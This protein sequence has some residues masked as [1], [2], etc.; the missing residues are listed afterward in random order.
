MSANIGLALNVT[1]AQVLDLRTKGTSTNRPTGTQLAVGLLRYETDTQKWVYF[2]NTNEWIELHI[3]PPQITTDHLP[4]GVKPP[5]LNW[6]HIALKSDLSDLVDNAP[7]ALNTLNELAAALNDDNN[8]FTTLRNLIPAGTMPLNWSNLALGSDLNDLVGSAPDSLNTLGKLATAIN[9]ESTFHATIRGE[10]PAGTMPVNWSHLALDS[11]LTTLVGNPP[12]SLNTLEKLATAINND[13]AFHNYIRGEIPDGTRPLNWSYLALDSDITDLVGTAPE[14]LNTLGKLA[15]AIPTGSTVPA[16]WGHIALA[17]HNHDA[18]YAA[19]NHSHSYAAVNHNHNVD[20]YT[21]IQVDN[22]IP[23]IDLSPYAPLAG[24]TFTGGVEVQGTLTA[25]PATTRCYLG[26]VGTP[27]FCGFQHD[28]L[29]KDGTKYA[30]IQNSAGLT[31]LN[32]SP[33]LMLNVNHVNN[34]YLVANLVVIDVALQANGGIDGYLRTEQND[35][36][37]VLESS[38]ATAIDTSS[39]VPTSAAV[40]TYVDATSGTISSGELVFTQN[41]HAGAGGNQRVKLGNVGISGFAGISSKNHATSTNYALVQS[42]TD[43]LVCLNAPQASSLRFSKSNV[44]TMTCNPDNNWTILTDL[45]VQGSIVGYNNE[46]V[47]DARYLQTSNKVTNLSTTTSLSD[48]IP[49]ANAVTS[50]VDLNTASTNSVI[51]HLKA[52]LNT[53]LARLWA[54]LG[55]TVGDLIT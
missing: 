7:D 42:G 13:S 37:Y 17:S 15:T 22:L 5:N 2:A 49:T 6:D 36:R 48:A 18:S 53:E 11:D 40:K 16:T 23:S 33:F 30:V 25:G 29:A 24:A 31:V 28:A 4:G 46:T 55:V 45:D 51:T 3:D 12:D 27:N 14:S 41:V 26:D 1:T 39:N 38:K 44:A 35:L 54:V 47:S 32:G 50:Y 19:V 10:I 52:Q 8:A 21:K 43:G 9:N 34:M 20:Y